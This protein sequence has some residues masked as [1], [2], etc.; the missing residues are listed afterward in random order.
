M[1]A[2]KDPTPKVVPD[3]SEKGEL[4]PVVMRNKMSLLKFAEV[5]LV[6]LSVQLY[7]DNPSSLA[8]SVYSLPFLLAVNSMSETPC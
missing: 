5:L 3:Q 1:N 7:F 2:P 8:R 4:I 6:H